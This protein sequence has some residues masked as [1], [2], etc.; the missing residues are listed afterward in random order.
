MVAALISWFNLNKK[1]KSLTLHAL[2]QHVLKNQSMSLVWMI[3][4]IR[5]EVK[6][7]MFSGFVSHVWGPGLRLDPKSL[8]LFL[9][10]LEWSWLWLLS[11]FWLEKAILLLMESDAL[12]MDGWLRTQLHRDYCAG[13]TLGQQ[14]HV[15]AIELEHREEGKCPSDT[16]LLSW[17]TSW[18]SQTATA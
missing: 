13:Q 15:A 4:L 12:L 17:R 7:Q 6:L 11:S 1:K 9:T 14:Y 2:L 5:L 10:W 3:D 18:G 16:P 8:V